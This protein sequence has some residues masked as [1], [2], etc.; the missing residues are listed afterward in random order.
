MVLDFL[1]GKCS[2]AQ[3]HLSLPCLLTDV[4]LTLGHPQGEDELP[5]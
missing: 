2:T 4:D 1:L 5:S 3:P